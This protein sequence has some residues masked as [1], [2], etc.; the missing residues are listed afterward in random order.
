MKNFLRPEMDKKLLI[1]FVLILTACSTMPNS[2]KVDTK[3]GS[4]TYYHSE[5]VD[6]PTIIF[7]SG[8][9]ETMTSWQKLI[10]LAERH[11]SVF[12][13][14][15]AGFT[16]SQS[17]N[18][19]RDSNTISLELESVLTNLNIKPPYILVGHSLGGIYAQTFLKRNPESVQALL[20][21]DS[22]HPD[23]LNRCKSAGGQYCEPGATIPAWARLFYPSA[24]FGELKAWRHSLEQAQKNEALHNTPLTVIYAGQPPWGDE[25]TL[26]IWQKKQWKIT[27]DNH[28][29]LASL[30]TL[31]DLIICRSCGHYIH[32]E[33]PEIVLK[34]LLHLAK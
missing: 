22:I 25:K 1:F 23:N 3:Y 34:S 13:Y 33:N 9:G 20:L 8:L 18:K 5:K 14:N 32:Q 31:S 19:T 16:G 15:R 7:E 12:A 17:I 27:L 28:H 26:N 24:V 11:F 6:Y 30:S 29:H 21:I 10:P 4:F 2:K